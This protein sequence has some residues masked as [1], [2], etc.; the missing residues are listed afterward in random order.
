MLSTISLNDNNQLKNNNS[1]DLTLSFLWYV[2]TL[3]CLLL[4]FV[5][6]LFI[7]VS[8]LCPC[9]TSSFPL[10]QFWFLSSSSTHCHL[11]PVFISPRCVLPSSA[12]L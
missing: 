6:I 10:S 12:R 2:S 1:L 3:L 4:F 8:S 7:P 11:F 5:I 9:A